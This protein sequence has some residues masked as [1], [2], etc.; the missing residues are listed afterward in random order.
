[1]SLEAKLSKGLVHKFRN[2]AYSKMDSNSENYDKYEAKYYKSFLPL[3]LLDGSKLSLNL[4]S[5]EELS[6][7]FGF[8]KLKKIAKNAPTVN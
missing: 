7:G 1:M 2:I 8:K 6:D 5:F 4:R 3:Y